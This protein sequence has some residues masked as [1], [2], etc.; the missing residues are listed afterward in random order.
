[1]SP[2][3]FKGKIVSLTTPRAETG[4]YW[5]YTVRI[6]NNLSQVFTQ[7]PYKDGYDLTVGTSDRGMSIDDLPSKGLNYNHAIIVFG[8]LHG[9]ETAL[10]SDEQLQVDD[11][12]LLFNHYVNVLPNQGSRTIR[13]EE[14]ILVAL[15]GLRI[16]LKANNEPLVF[17]DTG[18]A[19]SSIF[20]T[21]K[22]VPSDQTVAHN[23]LDLSKFD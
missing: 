20:P 14:A 11:A 8:G 18:I 12:S 9:I 5:G 15:S 6:A 4:V 16:K 7:S 17:K 21:Q 13:T 1:M 10:E 2:P 23:N 22:S 19:T 3:S